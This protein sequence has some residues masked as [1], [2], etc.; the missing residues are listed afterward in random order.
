MNKNEFITIVD[1]LLEYNL[2]VLYNESVEGRVDNICRKMAEQ[3]EDALYDLA[4]Y[5][6]GYS[7]IGL[8]ELVE[9]R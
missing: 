9:G 2:Q 7:Y 4:I 8:S 5:G 6:V 3:M 1:Y